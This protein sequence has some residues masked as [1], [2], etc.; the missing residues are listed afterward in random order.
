[1]GGVEFWV[2]KSETHFAPGALA[3]WGPYDTR[4]E[5]EEEFRTDRGAVV[6]LVPAPQPARK[7]SHR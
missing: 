3:Y 5:A 7:K 4:E 2:V 1:M 6:V